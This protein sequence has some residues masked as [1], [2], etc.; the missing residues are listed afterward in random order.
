MSQS[1]RLNREAEPLFR[2]FAHIHD[3][4]DLVKVRGQFQW[5]LY[6]NIKMALYAVS[7]NAIRLFLQRRQGQ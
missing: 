1:P 3:A 4:F 6:F 5:K 2:H 7:R